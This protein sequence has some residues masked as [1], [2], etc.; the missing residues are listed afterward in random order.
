MRDCGVFFNV[1]EKLN[2][3]GK[4]SGINDFISF[5]GLDKKLLLKKLLENL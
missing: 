5:V 3:D 2:G 4:W 1:W